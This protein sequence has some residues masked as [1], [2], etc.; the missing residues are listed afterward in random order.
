MQKV[1]DTASASGDARN[2]DWVS[3]V[4]PVYNRASLLPR[5]LDS[6][7]AQ[8]HRP[9]HLIVVDNASTDDSVDVAREW[10]RQHES[11]QFRCTLAQES[12]RGAAA[13]RQHGLDLVDT[14]Y[15]TFF[16]SDDSMRPHL[17]ESGLDALKAA[18]ADLAAWRHVR[19]EVSGDVVSRP[20]GRNFLRRQFFNSFLATPDYLVRTDFIRSAGGWNPAMRGWDDWELGVRLILA[21]PKIA[22]VD[23][24][25]FDIYPQRESITGEN[26]W[27]KAEEWEQA[28]DM[29][30]EAI[31]NLAVRNPEAAAGKGDGV[32]KGFSERRLHEMVDYRRAVL[33]AH[34]RREGHPEL[35]DRL[36]QHTLRRTTCTPL[37]RLLLRVIHAYTAAGLRAAYLLWR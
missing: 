35:A 15:V 3:V 29:A 4:V 20:I 13:A 26:H 34:Y 6:I 2:Q 37:R 32:L 1:S 8:T 30:D 5:C 16:D 28:L 14:E 19:H 18:D 27:S 31:H 22:V 11:P 33:A 7:F 23:R 9:L 36:M 24:V 10:I 25:N 17:V 12:R 21:N